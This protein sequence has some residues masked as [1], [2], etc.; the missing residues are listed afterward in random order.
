MLDGRIAKPFSSPRKISFIA[1]MTALS[2]STN[3]LMI[4][5]VNVKIMDL[6]VFVAGCVMGTSAGISV[7]VLTWLV[8]GTLNPYGFD[9]STLIVTCIG[10]SFYG[11]AGGLFGRHLYEEQTFSP[12]ILT[13]EVFWKANIKF[14][15]AGFLLTFA[16]DM[17]T[18]VVTSF[19]FNIPLIP[20]IVSG[21]PFTALH[22]ISNFLF[23]FFG[24]N[25]L[26]NALI[27]KMFRGEFR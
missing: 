21:I 7:G 14:G 13:R 17:F 22:E 5:L 2:V 12:S 18:N 15:V 25:V 19:V 3:Y 23:F 4:G 10:E 16:Y 8:Y 9:L 27:K 26:A 6:L 20:Y 11:F 1:V 24:G